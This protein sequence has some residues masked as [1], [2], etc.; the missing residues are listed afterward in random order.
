MMNLEMCTLAIREK[1]GERT[2]L[3]AKLKFDCGS[4]GVVVIDGT[5]LPH[6]VS[7]ENEDCDCTCHL[8]LENLAAVIQKNLDPMMAI[9]SGKMKLS[10]D[11]A[12]AMKL[13]KVL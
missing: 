9:F 6:V 5:Q 10:G 2:G 4:D 8:S 7:N 3:D 13:Q 11:M 1:L 12:V